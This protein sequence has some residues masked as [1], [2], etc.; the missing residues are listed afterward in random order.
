MEVHAVHY[1]RKYSTFKEAADKPDGLAVVG[2]FLEA[3][4]NADNPCFTK[5]TKAV[6]DIIKVNTSTSVAPG[7]ICI[8]G[9][10]EH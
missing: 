4:D 8:F 10:K 6:Q 7:N 1:N 9:L 2:I 3:T 5:L